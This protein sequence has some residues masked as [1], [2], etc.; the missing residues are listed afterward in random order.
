MRQ[1]RG[2]SLTR[3]RDVSIL[4]VLPSRNFSI[5][6]PRFV[7]GILN[8]KI[9]NNAFNSD[10]F[11]IYMQ[12]IYRVLKEKILCAVIVIDNVPIHKCKHI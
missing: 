11:L 7:N 10:L 8:Y 6:A 9:E 5:C 4:P 3:S 12:D 1:E 2:Q